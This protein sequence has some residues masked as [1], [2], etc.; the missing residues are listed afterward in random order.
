M[1][2]S[3]NVHNYRRF[4]I[5]HQLQRQ[6][7]ALIY[8]HPGS[9]FFFPARLPIHM[10]Q[11][12]KRFQDALTLNTQTSA[13]KQFTTKT[14]ETKRN[15]GKKKKNAAKRPFFVAGFQTISLWWQWMLI[16]RLP[17]TT[18]VTQNRSRIKKILDMSTLDLI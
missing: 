3:W 8:K 5:Q 14:T 13:Q 6:T 12:T 4:P 1:Y 16:S 18:A 9:P 7:G 11:Y 15:T 10:S 17:P 2:C